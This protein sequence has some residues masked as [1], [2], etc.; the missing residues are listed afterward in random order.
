MGKKNQEAYTETLHLFVFAT[1][2]VTGV[3][4]ALAENSRINP[5]ALELSNMS[6]GN[7]VIS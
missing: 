7:S 4:P 1:V 5:F 6:E 3:S 2:P